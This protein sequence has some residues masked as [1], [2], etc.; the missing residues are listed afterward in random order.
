MVARISLLALALVASAAGRVIDNDQIARASVE[1]VDLSNDLFRVQNGETL[2]LSFEDQSEDYSVD[3]SEEIHLNSA[4]QFEVT[5]NDIYDQFAPE[6][7]SL[8]IDYS[9]GESAQDL[10]DQEWDGAGLGD[11]R[12]GEELWPHHGKHPRGPATKTLYEIIDKF[13]KFKILSH[14]VNNDSV[15]VDALNSTSKNITL[16][17]PL[18]SAFKFPHRGDKEKKHPKIPKEVIRAFVLYHVAPHK[19]NGFLLRHMQ[20]IPTALSSNS[21]LDGKPQRIRLAHRFFHTKLNFYAGIIVT[22]IQATNGLLHAIDKPLIPPP[23]ILTSLN[24]FPQVFS[25]LSLALAKTGY[26][27]VLNV[28]YSSAVMKPSAP[29]TVFAPT[30]R[31]FARLPAPILAWLFS[32][33]G[34]QHLKYVLK[35]H[36]SAGSAWYSDVALHKKFGH[37]AENEAYEF[38]EQE[39][40]EEAQPQQIT[41][42][43]SSFWD[44]LL[45]PRREKREEH[46]GWWAS[47]REIARAAEDNVEA[48]AEEISTDWEI[49]RPKLPK[50]PEMPKKP[51]MPKMPKMPHMP[52]PKLPPGHPK[53]HVVFLKDNLTSL[54]TFPNA[55]SPATINIDLVAFPLF[56]ARVGRKVTINKPTR[57]H[58][59]PHKKMMMAP[60]EEVE[61]IE[62]SDDEESWSKVKKP[63]FPWSH[64]PRGPARSRWWTPSIEGQEKEQDLELDAPMPPPGRRPGRG[65]GRG[66]GRGRHPGA[67]HPLPSPVVIVGDVPAWNGV[68]H[69]VNH[70]LVPNEIKRGIVEMVA[71]DEEE[72]EM[73]MAQWQ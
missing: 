38:P 23:S 29:F 28:S 51:K 22:D 24:L 33:R 64:K 31:A 69:V 35:Y 45:R 60:V 72:K 14:V 12:C 32:S 53:K 43:H 20:S 57:H 70:L 56:G 46:Q 40:E 11:A 15:L 47:A 7:A 9:I 52:H 25:T 65:P 61:S 3:H 41:G 6:L 50:M 36:A 59:C 71:A 54:L 10:Y 49:P 4:D 18:D 68:V 1:V 17:A 67:P 16:F 42:E 8:D 48:A 66:R 39:E 19:Y 21:T 34:K 26:D 55:S 58:K 13:P 37:H 30:N 44:R 5:W 73:L 63:R 2:D 62:V 27:S